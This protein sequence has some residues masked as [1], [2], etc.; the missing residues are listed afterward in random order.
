MPPL[1]QG[2][3]VPRS[4]KGRQAGPGVLFWL[5]LVWLAAL[6]LGA[7]LAPVLPIA[8]P[9]SLGIRTRERTRYESPGTNA[10]FGADGQ[11]RDLFSLVLHGARPSLLLG[12]IVTAIAASVGG[13]LGVVA[14]YFRGRIDTVIMATTD[15]MLAFPGLILLAA[16]TGTIG[17]ELWV[18]T[19]GFVILG[20][21][22]YARIVRGVTLSIGGREFVEAARA[23]GAGRLRILAREIVPNV[24]MPTLSFAFLGFAIVIA[25]EGGLAF[26]GL[27]LD[28]VTWGVLI[29]DGAR[30]I[31]EAGHLAL[32]PATAMFLT[33]LALNLVSDKLS[34]PSTPPVPRSR[35]TSDSDD[36]HD[37]PA[38]EVGGLLTITD[39]RTD[40]LT[41]AGTVRPVDSVS[42]TVRPGT[43]VGI[44]GESGSG[45]TMLI[46]SVLGTF[47]LVEARRHG[48]VEL[49]GV[50]LLAAS[51]HERRRILGTE[52]GVVFQNPLTALNPVRTIGSQLA[53]TMRVHLGLGR[54]DARERAIE[55]LRAVEVP[56][57]R[58][59]VKQYPHELS[60]GMRQRVTIAMALANEPRLL[61]ADEP[62]T[63]L[64][65]TIQDQI[66]RLLRQLQT[67]RDMAMVL[68]SHDLA[69]VRGW[70]DEIAVFYAGQIVER[71]PADEVFARPRMRYT[72]ALLE[73]RPSVGPDGDGTDL[74]TIE[75]QP[76][77]LTDPPAGCR[78]A[79]RCR[80]ARTRCFEEQP[81][82]IETGSPGH[83]YACWFPVGHPEAR[84]RDHTGRP[85]AIE[86]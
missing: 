44:V 31:T 76:P 75:G 25:A 56:E 55:L 69:V 43:T 8:D 57:P 5:S 59:R 64:D 33:I 37:V 50:D 86:A 17:R 52:I 16:L 13:L 49:D 84:Q 46:R 72:E 66:L 62:T 77:L 38:T 41:E 68:V 28:Q 58:L 3:G 51:D 82:L 19:L 10:W 7:L 40:L 65:V 80:W 45:K 81:P 67:E 11:G 4:E 35:S 54:A 39:L 24:V 63:A 30:V 53:E 34:Q 60:G 71:G 14:G 27:S 61:L 47:A 85:E 12:L 26:I 29:A 79:D 21:P 18:L 22:A 9:E 48:R 36:G 15:I 83:A 1:T 42:L 2:S 70:A 23:M 78:F 32:I 73:S 6:A 20:L 74:A